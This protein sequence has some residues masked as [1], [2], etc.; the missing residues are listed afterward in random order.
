MARLIIGFAG[1]IAAGKTHSSKYLINKYQADS[2]RFSSSLR[3]VAKRLYFPEDRETL[4]R[5]SLILRQAFGE[6]VLAE[7]IFNDAKNAKADLVVIDGVRRQEDIKHLRS[8]PNFKFVYIEADSKIRF[9]RLNKRGENIDDKSKTWE[10]FLAD[11][12][13]ET[14]QSIPPLKKLASEVIDNNGPVAELESK[15]D[16]LV[17]AID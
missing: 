8:L 7:V 11:H 17:L 13:L 4:A 14:E 12:K 16:S 9:E 2:C 1:K 5:L 6:E 15:L 3:D 10:Q